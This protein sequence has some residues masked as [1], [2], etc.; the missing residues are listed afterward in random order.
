[1]LYKPTGDMDSLEQ[2]CNLAR[3]INA[4]G[5][6]YVLYRREAYVSPE[7]DDL[8]V[9]FDPGHGIDDDEIVHGLSYPRRMS[10]AT[11]CLRSSDIR[12]SIAR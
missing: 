10:S 1:M 9:P 8:R 5:C 2:F 6:A 12:V 4:D 7:S 11:P 3:S